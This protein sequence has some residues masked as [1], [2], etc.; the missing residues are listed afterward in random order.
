MHSDLQPWIE[1][2]VVGVAEQLGANFFN[3]PYHPKWKTVQIIEVL[4]PSICSEPI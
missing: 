3:A 4:V 1:D 2:Y